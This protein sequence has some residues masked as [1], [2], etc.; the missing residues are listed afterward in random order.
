M[1]A[2][3]GLDDV[4]RDDTCPEAPLTA[5]TAPPLLTPALEIT[6]ALFGRSVENG[7]PEA[8]TACGCAEPL[9]A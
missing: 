9:G 1:A 7:H 4:G 3:T 5:P 2:E 6:L 8:E